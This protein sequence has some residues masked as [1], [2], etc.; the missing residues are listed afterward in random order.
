M[1]FLKMHKQ[2]PNPLKIQ[3]FSQERAGKTVPNLKPMEQSTTPCNESYRELN[4]NQN[5]SSQTCPCLQK[6]ID[7]SPQSR[8]L[9]AEAYKQ[10]GRCFLVPLPLRPKFR[11]VNPNSKRRKAQEKQSLWSVKS[12]MLTKLNSFASGFKD[13]KIKHWDEK[14]PRAPRNFKRRL[15]SS[16]P[17]WKVLHLKYAAWVLNNFS[18]VSSEIRVVKTKTNQDLY[19]KALYTASGPL[20]LQGTCAKR[21]KLFYPFWTEFTN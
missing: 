19:R 20:A 11:P 4:A 21:N 14:N 9:H 16:K 18:S 1:H 13:S 7:K 3:H 15:C 2:N 17:I 12:T 5:R 8:L 10:G 6:D